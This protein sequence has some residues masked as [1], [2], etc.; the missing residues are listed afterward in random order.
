MLSE[1]ARDQDR[2]HP[3]HTI[4]GMSDVHLVRLHGGLVDTTKSANTN[5][6]LN[7]RVSILPNEHELQIELVIQRSAEVAELCLELGSWV[8]GDYSF[9]PFARDLWGL[10]AT[11]CSSGVSLKIVRTGWQSFVITGGSG[12]VCVSYRAYAYSLELAETCGIVDSDYAILMGTRYLRPTGWHGYCTVTYELPPTWSF[13]HPSGAEHVA[14]STWRYPDYLTLLDTPVV[15]GHL[16]IVS[17][18]VRGTKIYVVCVDRTLGYEDGIERFADALAR[19]A[20][21][22]N[23]M[24]GKFPF[25]DYTFVLSF[26]PNFDWG[27]EHLSSALCGLG[28]DLFIDSGKFAF[29]VRVCAHELFHAWN[30]RRLKPTPLKQIDLT[31]GSYTE[32]L[33]VSEG[34][35][36]YYEFVTCV[37]AGLY[38][39]EQF[40]SAVVNYL[41]HLRAVPAFKRI[42]VLDSSRATFLNHNKYAGRCNN[43]IDYYD[44]GMLIAF[45]IDAALRLDTVSD[46]LD[47]AFADF[48]RRY[49]D[50]VKGF[51][52]D[53][54]ICFLE[55]RL[56]GLGALVAR[57][58]K[59]TYQIGLEQ[60]LRRLGF[61]IGYR[62]RNYVG[63]LF[64]NA[65]SSRIYNV[66]DDSP[67][68]R[69]GI[70]PDDQMTRIDGYPFSGQGLSW[71]T[72]RAQ[73]ITLEVLRGQRILTF[74]LEPEIRIE[75]DSVTWR[76]SEA[77]AE[78]LRSWLGQSSFRPSYG[79]V[80]PLDFYENFH[81]VEVLR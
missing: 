47:R 67:A 19:V 80:M 46:S 22:Y 63:L 2:V 29:A 23:L 4:L 37:R 43:S 77:Q 71:V 78:R 45:D 40:V 13:H 73:R 52:T 79:L 30:V 56:P 81:G 53:D 58:V 42:D 75:I 41:T 44:K 14:D 72:S 17:R 65:V 35:T 64:N 76:G 7:Y 16:N 1:F 18:M 6:E 59:G 49:V 55:D 34:F 21:Q 70:A 48:Y 36:R 12:S 69:S 20:G 60:S 11:D 51:T 5:S 10:N 66:L 33:W 50:S 9:M 3:R 31:N 24:F 32:G 8:P 39:V 25:E 74:I 68:G 27:L 38:T 57:E 26:S 62:K 61:E 54:V 28:T 15:M